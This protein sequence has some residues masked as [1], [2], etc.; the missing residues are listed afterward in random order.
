MKDFESLAKNTVLIF[1]VS[2]KRETHFGTNAIV[3]D[4]I[5]LNTDWLHSVKVRREEFE[6]SSLRIVFIDVQTENNMGLK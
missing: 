3:L 1:C 4:S 5:F 6:T 2:G